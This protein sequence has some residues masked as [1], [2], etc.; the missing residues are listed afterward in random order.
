ML[1]HVQLGNDFTLYASCIGFWPMHF[2]HTY[3]RIWHSH[4]EANFV[5]FQMLVSSVFFSSDTYTC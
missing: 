1:L 2:V 3:S 4:I 5:A